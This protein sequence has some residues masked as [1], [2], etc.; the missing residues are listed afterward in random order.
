MTKRDKQILAEV[1]ECLEQ[2]LNDHWDD[3]CLEH[4]KCGICPSRKRCFSCRC[5]EALK[6]AQGV[7]V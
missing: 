5:N 3:R 4:D 7:M 1:A 2:A 6:K